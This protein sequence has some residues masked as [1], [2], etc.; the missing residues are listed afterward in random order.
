MARKP[1]EA[2]LDQI[3]RQVEAQ[4]GSQPGIIARLLELNRSQVIC[5]LPALEEQ[6]LLLS[7][8]DKWRYFLFRKENRQL[9]QNF[10]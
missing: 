8:V 10:G 1:Q 6:V 4:P 5:S 2:R 7:E 3:Y 9:L